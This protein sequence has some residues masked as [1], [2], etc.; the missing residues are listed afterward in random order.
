MIGM[1]IKRISVLNLCNVLKPF[2]KS[3]TDFVLSLYAWYCGFLLRC[4]YT[5]KL[6]WVIPH[7]IAFYQPH[8]ASIVI[9]SFGG[10]I[11]GHCF[12]VISYILGKKKKR[13][14]ACKLSE[15]PL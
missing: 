3:T 13:N 2:V 15:N 12:S 11:D 6:G 8:L 7:V 10:K 9:I 4:L 5:F 1:R 14:A